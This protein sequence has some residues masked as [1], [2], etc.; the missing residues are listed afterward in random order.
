M[1]LSNEELIDLGLGGG[2]YIGPTVT[3]ADVDVLLQTIATRTPEEEAEL[4]RQSYADIAA[5]RAAAEALAAAPRAAVPIAELLVMPLAAVPLPV[6]LRGMDAGQASAALRGAGWSD[7]SIGSLTDDDLLAMGFVQ[8]NV[9]PGQ[10]VTAGGDTGMLGG[11]IG[12]VNG[13]ISGGLQGLTGGGLGGGGGVL[14][15][16]GGALGGGGAKGGRTTGGTIVGRTHG[17]LMI[18]TTAGTLAFVKTAR[19]RR[20]HARSGS[21]SGMKMDRLMEM[22]MMK[23]ILK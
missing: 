9:I 20:Y 11:I 8:S 19:R 7:S 13:L 23:S 4:S 15:A 1:T 10:I 18:K 3:Q 22:A 16:I 6:N 14:G 21:R 5:A 12:A 2:D 17:M